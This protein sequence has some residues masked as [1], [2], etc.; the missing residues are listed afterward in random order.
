MVATTSVNGTNSVSWVT[1]TVA[2]PNSVVTWRSS[3]MIEALRSWSSAAVG[4]STSSTLGLPMSARA[5]FT[6]WRWPPESGGQLPGAGTEADDVRQFRGLCP[7]C[8][9]GPT[10]QVVG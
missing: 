10:P 9:G 3:P 5:M 4:S 6:R 8:L 7:G 1:I 2:T